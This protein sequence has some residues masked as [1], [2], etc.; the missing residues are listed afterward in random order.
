VP[1]KTIYHKSIDTFCFTAITKSVAQ[2]IRDV[3]ERHH[4]SNGI[5]SQQESD[6]K[7]L[8]S[9]CFAYEVGIVS[10]YS[11]RICYRKIAKSCTRDA[12]ELH[13]ALRAMFENHCSTS[14][15]APASCDVTASV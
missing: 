11:N 14:N 2:I 13:A 1:H 15:T 12:W 7:L 4:L 8:Q 6:T 10:S 5:L 3:T 9:I